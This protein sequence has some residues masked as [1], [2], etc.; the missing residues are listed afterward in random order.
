MKRLNGIVKLFKGYF[1]KSLADSS[2]EDKKA[3]KLIDEA[4]NQI[5]GKR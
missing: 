5:L 2:L 4:Y 1:L 3:D